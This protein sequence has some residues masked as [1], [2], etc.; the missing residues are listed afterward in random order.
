MRTRLTAGLVAMVLMPALLVAC[1]SKEK[2]GAAKVKYINESDAICRDFLAQA[3]S[4]GTAK[5]QATAEKQASIYQDGANKLKA[6][7][8]PTES[9]E[10]ARQF[11]TDVENLSL[12]YTAAA[13]SLALKDQ[14]KVDRY[15]GEVDLIKK[16]AAATAKEYGY[17]DCTRING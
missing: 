8:P 4:A 7:T 16:R 2:P 13:R 6:P 3:A 10:L 9:V 17:N 11:T 5:D 15:F 1:T 14:A 12:G